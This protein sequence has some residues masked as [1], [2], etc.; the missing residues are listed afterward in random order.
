MKKEAKMKNLSYI[1]LILL[2]IGLVNQLLAER[3]VTEDVRYSDGHERNVMDIYW[4]TEFTNAPIVVSIPGG[5][6]VTGDKREDTTLEVRNFYYRRGCVVVSPNYRLGT[7]SITDQVLANAEID[8]AMAVAYIQENAEAFG[9]DP[10]R[11]VM[12]GLS[13]GGWL[14]AALAYRDSWNW[15]EDAFY[16]PEQLNAVAWY[17]DSPA[18]F[19]LIDLVDG[20][21]PP[22]FMIFGESEPGYTP[23]STGLEMRAK[24]TANGV[25]NRMFYVEGGWH[26]SGQR[27]V[28]KPRYRNFDL[29]HDYGKFLDAVLYGSE[30]PPDGELV[31]ISMAEADDSFLP[32]LTHR[33]EF[34]S[35][36]FDS[37]DQWPFDGYETMAGA[38]TESVAYTSDIPD[39]ASVEGSTMS[40]ELGM[41]MGS[42]KSGFSIDSEVIREQ[43]G[44]YAVWLKAD[45]LDAETYIVGVLPQ[46]HPASLKGA[47]ADSIRAEFGDASSSV[48]ALMVPGSW[49]HVVVSWDH[50]A[51]RGALFVD[52]SL[53]GVASFS[54][55][56]MDPT[57]VTIGNFNL[58]RDDSHFANQFKGHLYDLQFYSVELGLT[59]VAFLAENPGPSVDPFT[60]GPAIPPMKT[61][62]WA[63]TGD[64]LG[65]VHIVQSPLD[66]LPRSRVLDVSA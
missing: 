63:D 41:S 5:A 8:C 20:D 47:S 46:G 12:H 48:T 51:G 30:F 9:A 59:E 35:K 2:G 65:W 34:E 22:G 31:T 7:G 13:A 66:L 52:G 53:A 37:N 62:E 4:D 33:Y 19:Y 29:Y 54:P 21:D 28:F 39:G 56:T 27:M 60:V 23:A 38:H 32:A 15:P 43:N 36:L 58:D 44:S 16:K 49:H 61:G 17:G 11:V 45:Q 26:V 14:S 1:L 10:E 57:D 18:L 55:G 6:F 24:L 50:E 3:M 64:W 25:W 42:R 40:L